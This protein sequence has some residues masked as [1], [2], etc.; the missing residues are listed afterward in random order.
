[1]SEDVIENL[2]LVLRRVVRDRERD[3]KFIYRAWDLKDQGKEW[4][5]LI[6]TTPSRNRDKEY[7]EREGQVEQ[8]GS[9]DS[10]EHVNRVPGGDLAICGK[11]NC[12]R[13]R[14]LKPGHKIW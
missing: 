10:I 6:T 3:Q 5:K 2:C 9:G 12:L 1:M 7:P 13:R 8:G 4:A 11:L 14:S